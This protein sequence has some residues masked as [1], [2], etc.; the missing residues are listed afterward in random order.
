MIAIRNPTILSVILPWYPKHT[1]DIMNAIKPA[2]IHNTTTNKKRALANESGSILSKSYVE[3]I[4]NDIFN[5][6]IN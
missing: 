1:R 2:I 4:K 5:L 6:S 3:K